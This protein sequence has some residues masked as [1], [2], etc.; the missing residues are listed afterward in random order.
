MTLNLGSDLTPTWL[1][2]ESGILYSY[3]RTDVPTSDRCLGILPRDGGVRTMEFCQLAP[4]HDDSADAYLVPAVGP[5]GLLAYVNT[6]ARRGGLFPLSRGIDVATLA[7]P[8]SSQRVRTF[9][10][11]APSGRSHDLASDLSW[12]DATSLV[13]VGQ[14]LNY[15]S[16]CGGCS[17]D[18]VASGLDIMRL[19]LSGPTPV[20]SLVPGT[21]Y[22]S[23]VEAAGAGTVYYT[24]GGDSRVFRQDLASGVVTVVHDFGSGNIA[25][26]VRVVGN[27][28]IAVVG[29]IVVFGVDSTVGPVQSDKGGAL[30]LLDLGTGLETPVPSPNLIFRHP[31]LSPSGA[32]IVA[33]GLLIQI[34]T[35]R[36]STHTIIGV[37]TTLLSVRPDLWLLQGP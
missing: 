2:D 32:R 35:V 25:R 9:P 4:S 19:D 22:A 37:D 1:P 21:D 16:P 23:S 15:P 5:S 24:L 20:M 8:G 18:T 17:P 7:S 27:E 3:E 13:Y 29:G 6:T 14:L 33:E 30:V 10:Y 36:D 26:D 34:D 12:L 31:A 11:L 28:L